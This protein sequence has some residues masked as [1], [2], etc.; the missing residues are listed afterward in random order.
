MTNDAFDFSDTIKAKSDQLNA[1]DLIGGPIVVQITRASRGE[2]DQPLVLH[3]TD[4][5]QP[6]KPCK[7]SRRLLAACVGSTNSGDIVGRWV[8]LY[9][10]AGVRWAGKE[11]G[12][13]RFD[14]LSGIS[15]KVTIA[16]A[17]KRGQKVPHTVEV[18]QPPADAAP[19]LATVIRNAGT[20]RDHL[21]AW[22]L[23]KD[24]P[25]T[26]DL[27]ED[28]AVKLRDA[29]LSN[30]GKAMLAAIKAMDLT[31]ADDTANHEAGADG[32]F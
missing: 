27:P 8:R 1:D 31:P 18:L 16:L 9:R 3:L 22:L 30:K 32:E 23:S 13:I 21:D 25:T 5:H 20:D 14:A 24:K 29:L 17:E 28:D 15:R 11:V 6:W 2:S 4:G 12:G 19:D 10:N 7:T 26:A